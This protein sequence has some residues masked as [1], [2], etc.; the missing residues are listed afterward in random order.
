MSQLSFKKVG[1]EAVLGP[2]EESDG[3][4]PVSFD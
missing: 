3:C 1:G 2:A 4:F